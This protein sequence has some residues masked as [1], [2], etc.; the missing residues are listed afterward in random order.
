MAIQNYS[1]NIEPLYPTLSC[2]YYNCNLFNNMY[3]LI[4]LIIFGEN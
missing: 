2:R 1:C 3:F 4:F